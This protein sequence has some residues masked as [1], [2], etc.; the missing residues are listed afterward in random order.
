M[1]TKLALT[2]GLVCALLAGCG[3]TIHEQREVQMKADAAQ[4][5]KVMGDGHQQPIA[6]R[7]E[8]RTHA[9]GL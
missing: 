6:K 8:K 9:S 5:A 2:F 1:N 3:K 7:G 4:S